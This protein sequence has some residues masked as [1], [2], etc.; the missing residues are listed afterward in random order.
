MP[1][2]RGGRSKSEDGANF[3]AGAYLVVP[4]PSLPS[5]WKLRVW[6]TPGS[7]PTRAQLGT[8]AAL[9]TGGF[10]GQPVQLTAS[11]RAAAI[12]K[13]RRLYSQLKV[14]ANEIPEHIR[15]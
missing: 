13:L 11:E 6:E 14:P 4:D 12:G 1:V 8:A 9:S 2:K 15:G 3:P 5:S 10:R 7:G